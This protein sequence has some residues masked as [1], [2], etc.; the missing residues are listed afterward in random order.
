[1]KK[2]TNLFIIIFNALIFGAI[3]GGLVSIMAASYLGGNLTSLVGA[4]D[5]DLAS[6]V[7][8][9]ANL[10]IRDAKK[11]VVSQDVK[12]EETASSLQPVLV[13]AFKNS[14]ADYYFLENADAFGLI[15]STD[16]WIVLNGL[17]E[18]NPQDII[19]NYSIVS[20]DKKV[21][22]LDKTFILKI[23]GDGNIV[24]AHLKGASNLPI[25][26]MAGAYDLKPGTSVI[27]LSPDGKTSLN[28]LVTKKR[29]DLLLT[30]DRPDI[31]LD[32]AGPIGVEFKNSLVFNLSGDFVGWLDGSSAVRPNYTFLPAWRAFIAKSKSVL[33]SLG[34]NYLNLNVI[35]APIL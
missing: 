28:S 10:V 21:Y 34:V 30:S 19:K 9:R 12:V 8:N 31:H 26:Q 5:L 7:Y 13:S 24:L 14:N 25:R 6:S 29:P 33:P 23:S 1:M 15:L 20:Y 32:L 35:K 17:K 11:V 2:P 27:L 18:T 3:S 16:G 4:N 22:A